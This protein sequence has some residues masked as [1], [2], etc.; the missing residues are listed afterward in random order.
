MH[1][2]FQ[3]QQLGVFRISRS[4]GAAGGESVIGL[5]HPMVGLGQ[6]R[7]NFFD[8]GIAGLGAVQAG[9]QIRNRFGQPIQ[10]QVRP[11]QV[12]K[13]VRV[14]RVVHVIE[15]EQAQI[16]FQFLAGESRVHVA[17]VLD[18]DVGEDDLGRRRSQGWQNLLVDPIL[19]PNIRPI[20]KQPHM[21]HHRTVLRL[22]RLNAQA[23]HYISRISQ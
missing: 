18:D 10:L 11:A 3:I 2:G 9:S 20:A 14:I 22:A 1:N 23:F 19:P 12:K 4:A 13:N 5:P 21:I 16:A 17:G 8:D 6:E 15:V 7:E